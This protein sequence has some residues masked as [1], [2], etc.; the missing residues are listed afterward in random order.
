MPQHIGSLVRALVVD[1]SLADQAR[2]GQKIGK[3][4][5]FDKLATDGIECILHPKSGNTV[6]SRIILVEDDFRRMRVS[7]EFYCWNCVPMPRGTKNSGITLNLETV[8]EIRRGRS[9]TNLYRTKK[10]IDEDVDIV[11][12]SKRFVSLVFVDR[13]IDLEIS[14]SEEFNL[15]VIAASLKVLSWSCT[16]LAKAIGTLLLAD[17]SN[18]CA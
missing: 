13:T 12:D 2:E 1:E 5:I 8:L 7:K 4:Q 17:F 6:K 11:E 9:T 14:I 3:E 18:C 10:Y 16:L 15:L